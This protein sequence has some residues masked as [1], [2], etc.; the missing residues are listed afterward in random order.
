MSSSV[1][2]TVGGVV[3]VTHVHPAPQGATS[4]LPVGIQKFSRASPMALGTVRIMIGL[5]TLLFGIVMAVN[6]NTEGVSGGIF[7]WG[8]AIVSHIISMRLIITMLL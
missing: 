3:V 7:V 8:A 2:T 4:Q 1:S 5:M 6:P